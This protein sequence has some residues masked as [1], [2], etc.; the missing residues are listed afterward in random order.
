MDADFVCELFDLSRCCL[1]LVGV[2]A[3]CWKGR[4][5]L[6]A[7]RLGLPSWL[8]MA[9]LKRTPSR[10]ISPSMR[11]VYL[12]TLSSAY[13]CTGSS[14]VRRACGMIPTSI[15]TLLS[16]TAPVSR[17]PGRCRCWSPNVSSLVVVGSTA[18]ATASRVRATAKCPLVASVFAQQPAC[19][20]LTSSSL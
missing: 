6:R 9:A 11:C 14:G 5:V 10:R 13:W 1:R 8:Q 12:L 19:M 4:Q 17:S 2:C 16:K 3:I 18:L 15:A 20:H 7:S